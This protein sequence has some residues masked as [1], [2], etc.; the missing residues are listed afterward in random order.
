MFDP[1]GE[2]GS[3]VRAA[4]VT[5]LGPEF[6]DVDPQVRRGQHGDAQAD[7]ALGLS[8]RARKAP[9]AIAE[10]IVAALPPNDLIERAEIAG[11]GFINFT[12]A[13]PWLAKAA[14]RLLDDPR[15]GVPQAATP[16]RV[17]IDYSAPNVAKEMH[18]GHL[19]STVLGDALAR[20]FEFRGHTVIRQNHIGDWGTPFG[21]LIEHLIDL[22]VKVGDASSELALAD[23]SSF[24]KAARKKFDEDPAFADRSR[25]RVVALQGGD[26]ETLARWRTLV[27]ISTRYFETVYEALD[28]TLQRKDVA[29]ESLYNDKL[30]PLVAELEASGHARENDGALCVFPAGFTNKEGEP[31]PLIVRKS[32]GGFGYAT[33]DLA[34]IRYRLFDLGATRLLYVV[35]APQAQHFSMIFTAARELGWLKPSARAEHVA[36]G[37]VLGPDR[38]MLRSREGDAVRLVDLV[39]EAIARAE[40]VLATKA[41]DLDAETRAK[42]GKMVGVGSLKYAD[43]SS[44]RVKDYVFDVDRMVSFD[45]NTSGYLQYAYARVRAIFRK[46]EGSVPVSGSLGPVVLA[47]AADNDA[48]ARAERALVLNLL[49][50][51]PAVQIVEDLLE[52]HRLAGYLYELATSFTSFYEKCPI[53]SSTGELRASRLALAELTARTLSLALGLL[54]ISVPERM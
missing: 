13:S 53:L 25:R 23:L 38:R 41:P 28:V 19:R 11:P 21:M 17:V 9:R 22:D 48:A 35:G 30:A 14:T 54:G 34:A 4:A 37:S 46:V 26:A 44:D 47:P 18:V 2:L 24:Y 50:L 43:L 33:T 36:F 51:A 29:G 6:S 45:G 7:L 52:P 42:V 5:A 27:D 10:S 20:L 15:L 12:F 32:D 49:A 3:L 39:S 40:S 8:K 1:L 16:E 31:L